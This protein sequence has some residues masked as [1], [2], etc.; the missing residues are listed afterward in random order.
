ML[1]L[2]RNDKRQAFP[3]GLVD[4]RQNAELTTVMCPTLDEVV[5]P[6]VPWM[7]LPGD[8]IF[9]V[10]GAVPLTIAALKAYWSIIAPRSKRHSV[11][12]IIESPTP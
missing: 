3:T 8:L 7:R 12:N 10:F 1:E 9:I 5:G 11:P 2:T 4:D 6:Y